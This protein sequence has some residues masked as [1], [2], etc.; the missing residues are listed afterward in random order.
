MKKV[1]STVQKGLKLYTRPQKFK[2]IMSKPK[3]NTLQSEKEQK[4]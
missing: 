4:I 3:S 2:M 1:Q